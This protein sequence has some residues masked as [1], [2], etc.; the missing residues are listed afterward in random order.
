MCKTWLQISCDPVI[1][2]GQRKEG[3]W[4]RI[5]K[6]H[7][8]VR[9]EFPMSVNRAL[10]TD[11]IKIRTETVKYVGFYSLVLRENQSGLTDEDKVKIMCSN[12]ICENLVKCVLYFELFMI[13]VALIDL[14]TSKATT[15]YATV[16]KK[17]FGFSHCWTALKNEPKSEAIV[18]GCNYRGTAR[19]SPVGSG[20]PS[21]NINDVD[22]DSAGLI[23]KRPLD[24]DSTKAARKKAMSSSSRSIG[25]L[26]KT[27]DI[28]IARL[29]HSEDKVEK[30]EAHYEFF[31]DLEF[32]KL[33][34]QQEQIVVEETKLKFEECKEK[35]TELKEALAVN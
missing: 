15:I 35:N 29:K 9:G 5:E 21:S 31:K 30:K 11:G 10:T 3:L 26:I 19:M 24:R 2:T 28:Q 34:V 4:A 13:V 16:H 8:K 25:Y 20:T 7:N 32:N 12:C 6:R 23:D 1:S 22:T 14:L 17:S 18:Q 27:H 33:E